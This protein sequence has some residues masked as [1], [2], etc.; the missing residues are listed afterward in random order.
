[1]AVESRGHT[2]GLLNLK[3]PLS[4]SRHHKGE[5]AAQLGTGPPPQPM[6]AQTLG[7]HYYN[8]RFFSVWANRAYWVLVSGSKYPPWA[9]PS[10][11]PS[12]DFPKFFL[13]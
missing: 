2:N 1:M 10:F 11:K 9:V 13:R 6:C 12:H 3:L 7:P 8:F 5:E 4:Q